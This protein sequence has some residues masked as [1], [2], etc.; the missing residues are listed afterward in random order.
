MKA[1]SK[2]KYKKEIL[3]FVKE[4]TDTS[5]KGDYIS[6]KCLL[7][8]TKEYTSNFDSKDYKEAKDG[9][10][11]PFTFMC[12]ETC[13]LSIKQIKSNMKCDIDNETFTKTLDC[14]M[15]DII[16]GGGFIGSGD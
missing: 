13:W 2:S 15:S 5:N 9:E 1:E 4:L 11:V 8:F 3:E 12:P 6:K 10:L 16:K 7:A 14:L